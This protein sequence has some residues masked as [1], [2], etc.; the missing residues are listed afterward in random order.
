[1]AELTVTARAQ[2]WFADEMGLEAGDG[3]RFFGK[4]GG[5]TNAHVGFSTG[6]AIAQPEN[7]SVVV[8][9]AGISYFFEEADDWFFG[10]YLLTVDVAEGQEEPTYLYTQINK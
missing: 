1:M 7:P 2:K 3:V 8:T 10:P 4:Y 6:V 5:S 9:E